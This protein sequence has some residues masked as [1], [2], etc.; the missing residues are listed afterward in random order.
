VAGHR[1]SVVA[2]RGG[3]GVL[4]DCSLGGG[5]SGRPAVMALI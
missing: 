4:I 2:G 1:W 3:S 5:R